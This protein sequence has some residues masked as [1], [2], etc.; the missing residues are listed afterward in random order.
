MPSIEKQLGNDQQS[1]GVP[2]WERLLDVASGVDAWSSEETAAR[3]INPRW[4]VAEAEAIV[5]VSLFHADTD[6]AQSR[7]KEAILLIQ[8]ILDP[9]TRTAAME[10]LL[11]LLQSESVDLSDNLPI[12]RSPETRDSPIPERQVFIPTPTLG[13]LGWRRST[14]R[15]V[16][17]GAALAA[18]LVVFLITVIWNSDS[19][20][21]TSPST[22]TASFRVIGV[23][24]KGSNDANSGD[25][26]IIFFDAKTSVSKGWLIQID[27]EAAVLH[28]TVSNTNGHIV[29]EHEDK[30]DTRDCY[31]YG[32]L[33]LADKDVVALNAKSVNWLSA[34]DLRQLQEVAPND[35]DFSQAT[36]VI[37]R[38]LQA[39]GISEVRE[40]AVV[41][42]RHH[43]NQRPLSVD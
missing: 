41:R 27:D 43:F 17:D 36:A 28:K 10:Y 21:P 31:E 29:L 13:S 26:F 15:T 35:P 7:F 19:P 4:L 5:T 42:K 25:H 2:D 33:L 34:N 37:Q 3:D 9:D 6:A 39:A 23:A 16:I 14:W 11:V 12:L 18:L 8:R 1:R 22:V 38:A 40:I 32:V 20:S 30:F 24:T